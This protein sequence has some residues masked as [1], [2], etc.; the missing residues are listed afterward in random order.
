MMA[1][2][3]QKGMALVDL[4]LWGAVV[5]AFISITLTAVNQFATPLI[6]RMQL[7]DY[8]KQNFS[9]LENYY[10]ESV[11]DTQCY[12]IPSIPDSS[13]LVSDGYLNSE[14]IDTS[15]FDGASPTYRI[16]T[17]SDDLFPVAFEIDV[18]FYS[19]K[20]A[21]RTANNPYFDAL[22]STTMTLKQAFDVGDIN[23]DVMAYI[24]SNGCM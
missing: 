21:R 19:E 16:V 10:W 15:F 8:A 22:N 1:L 24:D 4:I 2:Q 11:G 23:P 9:A 12:S 3:K 7:T 14:V 17:N 5:L 13:D 6:Q 18:N 20:D